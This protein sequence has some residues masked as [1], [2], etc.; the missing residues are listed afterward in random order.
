M[1][2]IENHDMRAHERR[3]VSSIKI[4]IICDNKIIVDQDIG[5]FP[6]DISEGGIGIIT[7]QLLVPDSD[8]SIR[9]A[10]D[11]EIVVSAKGVVKYSTHHDQEH[12]RYGIMFVNLSGR[13]V[14]ERILEITEK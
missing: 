3:Q 11:D 12:R 6:L 10:V 5:G 14:L 9:L 4:Q 8:V 1:E 7:D 13:Q 2:N